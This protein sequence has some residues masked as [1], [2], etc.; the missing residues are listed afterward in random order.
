LDERSPELIL[1]SSPFYLIPY[2]SQIIRRRQLALDKSFVGRSFAPFSFE[3]DKSKIREL[4]QALGDENP[5]FRYE[6]AARA[7]GLPGIVASPTFPTLLKWWGDG[8][9]VTHIKAM[10]GDVLRLLHGEE[11][12]EY[13]GLIRPGDV[14]T[15]R[16]KVVSIDEKEGRSGHLDITT[17]KTEYHNQ[18]GELVVVARS[19]IVIRG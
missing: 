12:Y 2:V 1:E 11:E 17:L 14:I 15:G 18:H 19:T 4:A 9:S 5:I 3:V 7:A 13:H 8:G 6:E 10:G 16:T